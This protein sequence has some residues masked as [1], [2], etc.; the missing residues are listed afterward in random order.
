MTD[1][2]TYPEPTFADTSAIGGALA[3]V[4]NPARIAVYD[5][6]LSSPRIIDI[7]PNRTTDFIG[8]LASS[9]YNEAREAGGSIPFT[10]ILQVTENFIHARFTEM[11]VSIFDSG[12]TI[13]FTDQ[14]PGIA[15]KEK[16]QLPG[17]SSATQEMKQYINGVGSGLPIVKEYLETKNGNIR[18]EDNLESG[19]VVTISV[20]DHP[21]TAYAQPQP[22]MPAVQSAS[23]AFNP[24]STMPTQNNEPSAPVT[25]DMV[26]PMLSKRAQDFLPLFKTESIWGI[27]DLSTTAGIPS[28]SMFNELKKLRDLG[29][30]TQVGKKYTLTPFGQDVVRF[31]QA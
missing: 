6:L 4:N 14:G 18:I 21:T 10:V 7:P 15:D 9:V 16:A 26:L 20:T 25:A 3:Y 27:K 23:I 29:I 11:V 17:Y 24:T 12:K 30:I 19:A 8:A 1:N 13:R 5:D 22:T 28:G 31:L 2:L